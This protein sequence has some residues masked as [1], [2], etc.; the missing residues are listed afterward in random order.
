MDGKLVSLFTY[1]GCSTPSAIVS[2]SES[3]IGSL[4]NCSLGYYPC[5]GILVERSPFPEFLAQK[6]YQ[7]TDLIAFLLTSGPTG[8]EEDSRD[9]TGGQPTAREATSSG[10]TTFRRD[11]IS[12]TCLL[13][14]ATGLPGEG[15]LRQKSYGTLYKKPA[16]PPANSK[17]AEAVGG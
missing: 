5:H 2:D 8:R 10:E 12:I 4:S 3:T 14:L 9:T 15:S 17:A 11:N 7:Q 1:D 6:P 16:R 13:L